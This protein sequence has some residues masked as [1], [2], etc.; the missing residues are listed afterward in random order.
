MQKRWLRRGSAPA[1]PNGEIR[2]VEDR[3]GPP[4]RAYLKLWER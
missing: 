4:S 3:I 1:V 2:F